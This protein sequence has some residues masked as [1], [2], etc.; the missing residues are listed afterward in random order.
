MWTCK[1]RV[2]AT[3]VSPNCRFSNNEVLTCF[4]KPWARDSVGG[5]RSIQTNLQSSGDLYPTVTD[6]FGLVAPA[7]AIY[8]LLLARPFRTHFD[9]QP[10]SV[11]PARPRSFQSDPI[12][13]D[14]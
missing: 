3:L 14:I 11:Y 10:I 7:A 2:R 1:N 6:E 8:I 9:A 4:E 12:L 5:A 13:E